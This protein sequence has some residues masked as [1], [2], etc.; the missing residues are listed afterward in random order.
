MIAH[1]GT[2]DGRLFP[3]LGEG[4]GDPRLGPEGA[5][6]VARADGSRSP[7]SETGYPTVDETWVDLLEVGPVELEALEGR[8][9]HVGD[10]DVGPGDQLVEHPARRRLLQVEGDG[11]LSAVVE[12]EG[13]VVVD[14]EARGCRKD[15]PKR[16]SRPGLDLDNLGAPVGHDATDRR[17]YDPNVKL[18]DFHPF[19]R[20]SHVYTS[21][22]VSW[23]VIRRCHKLR[24]RKTRVTRSSCSV[25]HARAV[26]RVVAGNYAERVSGF[27]RTL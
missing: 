25:A 20:T 26:D 19:E 13:R 27:R 4:C 12:L 9:A 2:P 23:T 6:V 5:D 10:E 22:R 15:S 1:P 7:L 18:H 11:P 16:I 3:R 17:A 14:V 24:G 21:P 8:R